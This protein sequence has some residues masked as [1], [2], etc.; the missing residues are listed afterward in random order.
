MIQSVSTAEHKTEYLRRLS[1]KPYF[2]AVLGTHLRL[3]GQHPASGW[4][5][6]LLPGTAVQGRTP[7]RSWPAFCGFSAPTGCAPSSPLR[8][9]AGSLPRR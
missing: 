3:F 8:W 6:Y 7:A 2:E 4:V 5:F 1:G 9:Q